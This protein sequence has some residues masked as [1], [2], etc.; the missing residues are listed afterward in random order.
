M[1][2]LTVKVMLTVVKNK[3]AKAHS[4]RSFN[5]FTYSALPLVFE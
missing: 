3:F 4:V 2:I 5:K 1:P